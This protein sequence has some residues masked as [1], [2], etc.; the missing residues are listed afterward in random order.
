MGCDISIMSRH[1]LDVSSIARLAA[2]LSE[3]LNIHVEY[4]YYASEAYNQLLGNPEEADFVLL[5]KISKEGSCWHYR[6]V[7]EEYQLKALYQKWGVPLFEK[8]EFWAEMNDTPM[9]ETLQYYKDCIFTTYFVLN[10]MIALDSSTSLTIYN[11]VVSNELFYYLRWWD[12]TDI[13]RGEDF[14]YDEAV[15]LKFFNSIRNSTLAL[16]GTKAYYVNNQC[17]HL[18]GVGFGEESEYTWNALETFIHSREKLEV[19][20]LSKIRT[21]KGYQREVKSKNFR[22]LAFYDDFEDLNGQISGFPFWQLKK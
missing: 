18:K 3:R 21:D 16:G 22:D 13:M 6:L 2:D 10:A 12:F 7:E 1:T 11:E 17:T 14:Y 8:K 5:G 15:L 9:P 20:S 4:G 19:V